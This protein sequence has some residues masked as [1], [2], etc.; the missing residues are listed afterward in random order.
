MRRHLH[1]AVVAT[2]INHLAQHSVKAYGVGCG[3]GGGYLLFVDAIDHRRNQSRAVAHL[4]VEVVE[5]RGYGC[6]AVCARNTHKIQLVR[7]VIV[8]GSGNVGHSGVGILHHHVAHRRVKLLG[9]L[10]ADDNG[11]TRLDSLWY[12]VMA[13]ALRATHGKEAVAR[14][15]LARIVREARNLHLAC[16]G[17][18]QRLDRG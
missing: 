12:K 8:V 3:V 13:I 9:K 5:Q 10:L 2:R 18:R 4:A 11:S 6:L 17:E 14:L 15:D 7:G 1:K 16:R